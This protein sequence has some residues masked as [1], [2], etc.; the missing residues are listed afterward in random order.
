MKNK[1]LGIALLIVAVFTTVNMQAND[2]DNNHDFGSNIL[3]VPTLA[4]D[5][6][7]DAVTLDQTHQTRQLL[8]SRDSKNSSTSKKTSSSKA[9]SRRT[10]KA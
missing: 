9:K 10:K 3:F 4:V 7:A 6:G 8:D 5:M 1:K 2:N